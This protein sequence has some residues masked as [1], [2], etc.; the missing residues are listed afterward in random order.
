MRAWINLLAH[1]WI[2]SDLLILAGKQLGRNKSS[3]ASKQS[4][5]ERKLELRRIEMRTW[6]SVGSPDSLH[7][8]Q[9]VR[10]RAGDDG[11][12]IPAATS[13]LTA[14]SS[15]LSLVEKLCS[16]WL[17]DMCYKD[18]AKGNKCPYSSRRL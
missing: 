2:G 10:G 3:K 14:H 17:T 9:D 7:F 8:P 6:N 11:P 15:A 18:T 12:V 16:D 4:F 13:V 5:S 1:R